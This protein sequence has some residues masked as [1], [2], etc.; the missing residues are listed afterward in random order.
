MLMARRIDPK[1]SRGS[2]REHRGS[3][4][5]VNKR[6]ISAIMSG[7]VTKV[8]KPSS[9]RKRGKQVLASGKNLKSEINFNLNAFLHYLSLEMF[10]LK[11]IILL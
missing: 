5:S 10:F 2:I 11:K 1:Y 3:Q 6:G 4:G 7:S 9:E 8:Q